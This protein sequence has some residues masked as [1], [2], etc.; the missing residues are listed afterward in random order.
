MENGRQILSTSTIT[1][2]GING[3]VLA[4]P[5]TNANTAYLNGRV[6]LYNLSNITGTIMVQVKKLP[7]VSDT[8]VGSENIGE[9]LNVGVLPANGTAMIKLGEDCLA[10]LGF[11]TTP[12]VENGGNIAL[13]IVVYVPNCV[14]MHQTFGADFAY[15]SVNCI[16]VAN[17]EQN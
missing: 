8:G 2:W 10:D 12:Y 14:G 16:V 9:P 15:G 13:E 7:R 5:W 6:Y 4:V 3:T 17:A 11:G 1:V